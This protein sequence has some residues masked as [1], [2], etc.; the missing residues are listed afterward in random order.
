MIFLYGREETKF[1]DLRQRY[2]AVKSLVFKKEAKEDSR[3]CEESRKIRRKTIKN[4]I[5]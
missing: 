5:F 2:M 3:K 1:E 4:V